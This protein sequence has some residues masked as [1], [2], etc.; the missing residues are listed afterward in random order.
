MRS[1]LLSKLKKT[2]L[3]KILRLR[4]R[5]RRDVPIY[6]CCYHKVGSKLLSKVFRKIC[7]EF[8]WEFKAVFGKS[9]NIP[10][11]ADIVSFVHSLVDFDSVNT[12][13][14]GAHFIRDPRDIIVS[15]Y[16]YHLRCKEKWCT[17]TNFDPSDPI[18]FPK[19]PKSQEYRDQDWKKK[20][21]S[22]LGNKS[23]QQNLRERTESE[24]LLFEMDHYGA[25]TIESMLQ[26]NYNNPNFVE[27]RFE[28]LMNNID[29]I[30]RDLF[31]RF[32]FS[33]AQ[34]SRALRIVA[35]NDLNR[36][37]EKQLRANKHISSRNITKWQ[38]YFKEIH[39]DAFKQKFGDI[40]IRLGY[41][42]SDRW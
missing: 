13:Y 40:L 37:T 32:E 18:L 29:K 30:F 2:L 42:S 9:K 3:K 1:R 36:F 7:W 38:K 22:S 19:V 10:E 14:V 11:D 21:L 35:K 4:N 33:D 26:W 8:G 17:N 39:R 20:Y 25:W 41:E 16:L 6:L 27:L 31:E 15:G 28:S 12:P 24:G 5:Q 23:Y 34:I